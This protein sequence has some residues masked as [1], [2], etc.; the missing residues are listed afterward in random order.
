MAK[1]LNIRA[2]RAQAAQNAPKITAPDGAEFPVG[3]LS[4]DAYL[5]ILELEDRF[6]QLRAR[7][8][9]DG[10]PDR[11]TQIALFTAMREMVTTLVPGFPAG[12]LNLDELFAVLAFAQSANTPE[13]EQVK[14]AAGDGAPGD[15]GS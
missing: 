6:E 11:A 4:L 7:E 3:S 2:L 8:K 9:A 10:A 1:N 15:S 14:E 5:G 12:S 13:A